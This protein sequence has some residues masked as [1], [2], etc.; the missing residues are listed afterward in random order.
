MQQLYGQHG[1]TAYIGNRLEVKSERKDVQVRVASSVVR[2]AESGDLIVKLV[3]LLPVAVTTRVE[4]TGNT[5][6]KPMAQ[7]IV[8]Q[9]KPTDQQ[10]RP[11]ADQLAVGATFD[12]PLPAYSFTI[13]RLSAADH[14]RH[15]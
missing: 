9:G 14:P 7:R 12:C 10:A 1:G 2:D 3:N 6:W 15:E 13:V 11:Q 5:A 4:V 8:L